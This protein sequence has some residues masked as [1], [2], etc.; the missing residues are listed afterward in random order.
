MNVALPLRLW[1]A[2][3]AVDVVGV[4]LVF[5]G[6]VRDSTALLVAG[7]ALLVA[8]SVAGMVLGVLARAR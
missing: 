8:T 7:G 3:L 4:L 5:L 6:I 1:V 2:L